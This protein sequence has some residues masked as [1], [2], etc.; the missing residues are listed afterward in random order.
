MDQFSKSP[1]REGD[2]ENDADKSKHIRRQD[3]DKS[4]DSTDYREKYRGNPVDGKST[5][6]N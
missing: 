3:N 6:Q 2:N 5:N 4:N 1:N